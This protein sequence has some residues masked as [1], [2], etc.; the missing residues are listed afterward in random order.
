MDKDLTKGNV[1]KN[2]ISL[3]IPTVLG[4]LSQTLYD[5]VDMIWM[6]KISPEAIAGVTIF[7]T[8][9]WIVEVQSH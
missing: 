4:F 9:F 5:L 2:L 1:T 3:A 6:G 7:A 8:I